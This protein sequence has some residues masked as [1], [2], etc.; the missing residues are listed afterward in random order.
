MTPEF[1][2]K[3]CVEIDRL[4]HFA[5]VTRR[6]ICKQQRVNTAIAMYAVSATACLLVLSQ[7]VKECQ[8]RIVALE[9]KDK[10]VSDV[11]SE[12]EGTIK[13]G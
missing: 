9:A 1:A 12:N 6:K 3:I 8:K 2:S 5:R 13:E 10:P 11:E 4:T 7:T